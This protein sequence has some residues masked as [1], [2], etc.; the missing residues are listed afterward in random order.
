M[1]TER[2]PKPTIDAINDAVGAVSDL[3]H[4]LR[5]HARAAARDVK[6]GAKTAKH[7]AEKAGR[8]A[9]RAGKKA[10]RKVEAGGEGLLDKAAKAWHDITGS[11]GVATAGATVASRKRA[12]KRRT[13]K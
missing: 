13:R 6:S 5:A 12:A 9:V 4:S 10:V 8:S 3:L 11:D 2:Q 1:S 7:D